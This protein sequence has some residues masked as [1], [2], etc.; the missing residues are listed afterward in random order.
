MRTLAAYQLRFIKVDPPPPRVPN[1]TLSFRT[2]TTANRVSFDSNNRYSQPEAM[3]SISVLLQ[4]FNI[5]Q[6]FWL[7]NI[8]QY[9]LANVI[10]SVESSHF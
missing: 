6:I 4:F 2:E 10:V 8:F 3:C 9:A 7:K 5:R 1:R